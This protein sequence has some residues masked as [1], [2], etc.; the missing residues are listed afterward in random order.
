MERGFPIKVLIRSRKS[1]KSRKYE[2]SSSTCAL[3]RQRESIGRVS[4]HLAAM[5]FYAVRV[6]SR[7]NESESRL[8]GFRR[9]WVKYRQVRAHLTEV[10][11]LGRM[12]FDS[13][14]PRKRKKLRQKFSFYIF[15]L[16]STRNHSLSASF[17]PPRYLEQT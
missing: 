16:L 9:T 12:K 14:F 1:R 2:V 3:E 8:N 15:N 7:G 6:H 10:T 5:K 11:R 4:S 17:E 13:P